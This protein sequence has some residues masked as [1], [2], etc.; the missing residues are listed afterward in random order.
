MGDGLF[1]GVSLNRLSNEQI[2]E[3]KIKYQHK[4]SGRRR[5]Q[6][7]AERYISCVSLGGQIEG[8][9]IQDRQTDTQVGQGER[10]PQSDQ[11]CQT[12]ICRD[13]LAAAAALAQLLC[14]RIPFRD[15]DAVPVPA[16]PGIFSQPTGVQTITQIDSLQQN[17]SR[18]C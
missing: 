4:C 17:S 13:V 12:S 15:A 6:R 16:D 1:V 18:C 3:T 8:E 7:L 2:S 5:S 10:E 11:Q 14:E 9:N